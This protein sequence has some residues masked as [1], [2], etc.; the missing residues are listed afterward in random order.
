MKSSINPR[1]AKNVVIHLSFNFS[2]SIVR[3]CIE[4]RNNKEFELSNQLI[5][6]GTSIGANLMEAQNAESSAD[7]KHKIKIALKEADETEY[8][9]RILIEV[10]NE[11]N[12]HKLL[13]S[14]QEIIKI[15]NKILSTLSKKARN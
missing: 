7:F 10:F 12:L 11:D 5:K 3:Y 1:Y 6:S 4:L 13:Q 15:L 2:V 14:V 9:I 8:W